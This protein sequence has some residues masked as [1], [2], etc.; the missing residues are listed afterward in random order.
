M[1]G[2]LGK[3]MA[4]V[5]GGEPSPAPER[6]LQDG[7]RIE[8]GMVGLQVLHTPGHTKGD[9]CLVGH[10]VVFT[11]DVLFVGGV[12]RTDLPGGSASLLRE[13]LRTK[14]LTLPAETVVYPGHDYG[15]H[16]TST[17]GNEKRANPFV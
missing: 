11:G 9:I 14:L 8:I 15:P 13:S 10:G 1:I 16:P 7:D 4:M 2:L 12:G 17:V 5:T 6:L 3:A